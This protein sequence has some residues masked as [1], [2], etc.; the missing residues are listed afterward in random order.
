MA[1]VSDLSFEYETAL[2]GGAAWDAH[3]CHLPQETIDA[4]ARCDSILFGSVGGPVTAQDEPK[5]KDSEKNALLGLRKEFQLAVNVRPA[6]VY[7]LLAELSPLKPAII[8]Q[9]VDM[10]VIRELVL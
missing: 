1:S 3:G 2:V 10:V 6:K 7:T 9:G 8:N 5:W 4:C